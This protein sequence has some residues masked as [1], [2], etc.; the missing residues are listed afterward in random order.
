[1][2]KTFINEVMENFS[3]SNIHKLK[4]IYD[5]FQI[6]LEKETTNRNYNWEENAA[7][8]QR[9]HTIPE[10]VHEIQK[11]KKDIEIIKSPIIGTF[12]SSSSPGL[13]PF[14][15]IGS[16][17]SKGQTLC[18]IEAMKVM[19]ELKSPCDGVIDEIYVEDGDIV[20]YDLPIFAIHR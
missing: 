20:E 14:V 4:M 11:D 8:E 6:E 12:Y 13:K 1:M 5:N 3:K 17:V 15:E 9:I 2:D 10:V 19:N 7:E 16:V 18:I